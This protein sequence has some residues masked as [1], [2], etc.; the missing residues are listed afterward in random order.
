MT[1][2][3]RF[4]SITHALRRRPKELQIP[5]AV[6]RC[7][8]SSPDQIATNDFGTG[9]TLAGHPKKKKHPAIRLVSR[10]VIKVGVG[11]R[12]ALFPG[13]WP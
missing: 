8:D 2:S 13:Y 6:R 5:A 12:H 1:P 3:I 4:S 10:G 9:M 11:V 7:F